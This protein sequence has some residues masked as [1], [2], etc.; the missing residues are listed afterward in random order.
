MPNIKRLALIAVIPATIGVWALFRPELLFVNQTVNEKLPVAGTEA[1]QVLG[2]GSFSSE[3]HETKGTAEIVRSGGKTYLRLSG[4]HTSNGPDVHVYLTKGSDAT[5]AGVNRDGFLDLGT[6]KGNIGDQNYE[7]PEGA[8]KSHGGVAIWCKRFGVNFGGATIQYSQK[9]SST[10]FLRLASYS[11]SVRVTSGNFKGAKGL[12][13]F[14]EENG[15]RFLKISNFKVAGKG[16]IKVL[17]V[18]AESAMTTADVS[19]STKITLGT[20]KRDGKTQRFAIGTDVDA[21]LYRSVSLWIN[22]KSAAIAHLRSDQET[23]KALAPDL[24]I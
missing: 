15:K 21:W 24:F 4:F 19:K 7:L 2:T 18:K 9:V 6:I 23:K 14:V 10:G 20:L 16:E 12:A 13:E 8:E 17:L 22:G 5:Q 3:A 1:S 11:D